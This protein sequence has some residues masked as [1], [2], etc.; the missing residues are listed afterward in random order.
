MIFYQSHLTVHATGSVETASL[1][2]EAETHANNVE[3]FSP[4]RKENTT[5]HHYKD[6]F[7]NAV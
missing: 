7:V 4:Y 1:T 3:E 5:L 2:F 6:R